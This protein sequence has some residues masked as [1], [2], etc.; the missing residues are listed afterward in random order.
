MDTD[1]GLHLAEH[2]DVQGD[3]AMAGLVEVRPSGL[4]E[5]IPR[6]I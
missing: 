5:E 1:G 3:V 2:D 6:K 4:Q